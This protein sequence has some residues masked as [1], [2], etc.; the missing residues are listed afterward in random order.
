MG[1]GGFRGGQAGPGL[2]GWATAPRPPP[3]PT[4]PPPATPGLPSVP[5]ASPHAPPGPRPPPVPDLPLA[6]FRHCTHSGPLPGSVCTPDSSPG[7]G[8]RI[9]G[10]SWPGGGVATPCP[11]WPSRQEVA[12]CPSDPRH[13]A[14][15]PDGRAFRDSFPSQTRVRGQQTPALPQAQGDGKGARP[16]RE[17][18]RQSRE[19][20]CTCASL[21]ECECLSV[22]VHRW[23]VR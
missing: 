22:C 13:R 6:S 14:A 19:S 2:R 9:G 7:S 16:H 23:K 15:L 21:C 5:Q 1:L 11:A 17:G 20:V 12:R 10:P 4:K 18:L 3:S 8:S